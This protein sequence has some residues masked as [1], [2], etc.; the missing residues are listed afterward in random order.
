MVSWTPYIIWL[1]LSKFSKNIPHCK[2][3]HRDKY[4]Q[5]LLRWDPHDLL[6]T[7][8]FQRKL[9]RRYFTIFTC[10]ECS[11]E[12]CCHMTAPLRK[13]LRLF[14]LIIKYLNN[15][16]SPVSTLSRNSS[17]VKTS[18]YIEIN[19]LISKDKEY[20]QEFFSF[21]S[22]IFTSASLIIADKFK[23]FLEEIC[24]HFGFSLR[25][26][27][28]FELFL[29]TFDCYSTQKSWKNFQ[30]KLMK[31]WKVWPLISYLK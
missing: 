23:E 9:K 21:S 6:I 26:S 2:R 24:P 17:S 27:L 20:F 16:R 18:I 29:D 30:G 3:N 28:E 19:N 8:N 12:S 31:Y 13:L 1:I 11:L 10:S 15:K 22:D 7:V 25:R 5:R 14:S 4:H